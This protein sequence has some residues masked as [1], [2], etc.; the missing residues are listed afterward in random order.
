MV[1]ERSAMEKTLIREASKSQL[2][3]IW[4]EFNSGPSLDFCLKSLRKDLGEDIDDFLYL[5]THAPFIADEIKGLKKK[6]KILEA[7]CGIGYWVFW[8]AEQGHEALGIDISDK[9]ISIAKNYSKKNHINN[10]SFLN[11]DVRSIPFKENYFD[12]IFSFGVIEHF[13]DPLPILFEFYRVLKPGGKIFVS[14]PNLYS[15]HS[16]KRSVVT[17]LGLWRVGYEKSYSQFAMEKTIESSGFKMNKSGIMPGEEFFG[18][19]SRYVPFIGEYLYKRFRKL[20]FYLENSQKLIGF[21]L[22]AVA[23]K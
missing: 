22:Y 9:A 18:C 10:C 17:L 13:R 20:S 23:E 4:N 14:V 2:K 1:F 19:W 12:Y 5:H 15:F 7:G 16:L 8:L 3:K 11:A 6:S 21:W